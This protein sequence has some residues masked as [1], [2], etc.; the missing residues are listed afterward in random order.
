MEGGTMTDANNVS[1]H[2]D[3]FVSKFSDLTVT[4]KDGN[5]IWKRGV[6]YKDGKPFTGTIDGQ[7][8]VNGVPQ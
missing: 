6:R 7:N 5:L 8:Y 2:A 4:D 1:D 3:R